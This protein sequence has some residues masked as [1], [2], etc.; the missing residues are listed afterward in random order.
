MN[1]RQI[2]DVKDPIRF[3]VRQIIDTNEC[4]GSWD[5]N[6]YE[7]NIEILKELKSFYVRGDYKT[8]LDEVVDEY[9]NDQQDYID[10][11]LDEE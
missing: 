6:I 9:I 4:Q 7:S 1:T 11:E 3:L 10:Q 8:E 5:E 2:E